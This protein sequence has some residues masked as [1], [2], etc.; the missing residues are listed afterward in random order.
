ML[1]GRQRGTRSAKDLSNFRPPAVLQ[2]RHQAFCSALLRVAPFGLLL[3]FVGCG[4][5]LPVTHRPASELKFEIIIGDQF[6]EQADVS[7]SVH[8]HDET[9]QREVALADNTRVTCNG[10]VISSH[11]HFF[12]FTPSTPTFVMGSCPRQPS[13]GSYKITYTD[14]HGASTTATVPVPS[15]SFAILSPPPDSTVPIPIDDALTLRLSLPTPPPGGNATVD[16]V[17]LTCGANENTCEELYWS[18]LQKEATPPVSATPRPQV[19]LT[20]FL[21]RTPSPTPM[22]TATISQ[23]GATATIMLRAD[24]SQVAPNAARIVVF[25]QVQ[26][27]PDPGGF[28]A[29]TAVYSEQLSSNITWAR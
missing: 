26:A 13:G 5:T 22:P 8:V 11:P 7:V 2:R 15:G 3:V 9:D 25:A 28:A 6:S 27:P 14:E 10:I 18:N 1:L 24:Y 20:P 4:A 19:T 23:D 17:L 12:P 16:N 21:E 29:A